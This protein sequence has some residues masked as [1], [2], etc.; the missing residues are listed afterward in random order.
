MKDIER[1]V[2]LLS[3]VLTSPVNED[4]YGERTRRVKLRRS[5]PV[6]I[7]VNVLIPPPGRLRGLL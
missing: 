7:C 1:R 5:V 2:H 6:Q 3:S 4:D